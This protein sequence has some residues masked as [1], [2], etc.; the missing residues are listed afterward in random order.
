MSNFDGSEAEQEKQHMTM[1]RS[2][3]NILKEMSSHQ[4]VCNFYEHI[5]DDK[6]R[7]DYLVLELVGGTTLKKFLMNL[8]SKGERLPEQEI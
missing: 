8:S 4:N 3:M 7:V 2:E 6:E 5:Y 1:L